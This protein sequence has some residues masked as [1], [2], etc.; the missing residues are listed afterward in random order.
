MTTQVFDDGSSLSWSPDYGYVSSTE[1]TDFGA[2]INNSAN[3]PGIKDISSALAYGFGRWVDYKTTPNM[4]QNT[5]PLYRTA[6]PINQQGG[7]AGLLSS[8]LVL[9]LIIGGGIF[10]LAKD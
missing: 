5:V 6:Q 7:L 4:P 2:S 9:L 1:A 8:D 3:F 10:M